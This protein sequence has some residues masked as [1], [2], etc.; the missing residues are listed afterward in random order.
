LYADAQTSCGSHGRAHRSSLIAS[1]QQQQRQRGG[2]ELLPS[3]RESS[4]PQ[5]KNPGKQ[6]LMGKGR[7]IIAIDP[8]Q[9]F[10]L[11]KVKV[12]QCSCLRHIP[13]TPIRSA[14]SASSAP[15]SY[16][17]CLSPCLL[18]SCRSPFRFVCCARVR[19]WRGDT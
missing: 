2:P 19:P 9:V 6:H 7:Q 13:T 15:M 1:Q 8:G 14:C 5:R 11:C 16:A 4:S 17:L 3:P 12:V 10:G 18:S